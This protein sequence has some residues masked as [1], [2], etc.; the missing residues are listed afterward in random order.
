MFVPRQGEVLL[1]GGCLPHLHYLVGIEKATLCRGEDLAVAAERQAADKLR[2]IEF[3]L[4][5]GRAPHLHLP[6][7]LW[8][9]KIPSGRSNDLAVRTN[10]HAGDLAFVPLEG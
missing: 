7:C 9:K 1:A 5:G 10:C 8:I 2:E 6:G 3:L 4:A